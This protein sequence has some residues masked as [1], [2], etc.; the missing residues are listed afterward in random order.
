MSLHVD[1]GDTVSQEG[2]EDL[3][4]AVALERPA[5][6]LGDLDAGVEHGDDGHD[7]RCDAAFGGTEK[8]A[9]SDWYG[10]RAKSLESLGMRKV[11]RSLKAHKDHRSC[12]KCIANR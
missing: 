5:E 2:G 11:S 4:D 8:E 3:G 7:T 1:V 9:E 6:T 12:G 10:K